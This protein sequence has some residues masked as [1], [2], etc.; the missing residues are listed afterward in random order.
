MSCP[1]VDLAHDLLEGWSASVVKS[2][3]ALVGVSVERS[4]LGIAENEGLVLGNVRIV[5]P[6]KARLLVGL[7]SVGADEVLNVKLLE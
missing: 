3:A 6:A 5:A 1:G 2:A 7:V 4:R